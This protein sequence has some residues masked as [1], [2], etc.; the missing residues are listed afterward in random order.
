MMK[1]NL[2]SLYATIVLAM[3]LAAGDATCKQKCQDDFCQ[4]LTTTDG[5]PSVWVEVTPAFGSQSP[6]DHT[7]VKLLKKKGEWES[8]PCFGACNCGRE[9]SDTKSSTLEDNNKIIQYMVN[10]APCKWP[11]EAYLVLG[12][13]HQLANRG[14]FHTGK[15]VK[16]ARMYMWS[17]F[18]Y[19]TYGYNSPHFREYRMSNCQEASSK[20]GT[21]KPGLPP[22]CLPPG[23]EQATP[24]EPD[25]EYQIYMEYFRDLRVTE[26]VQAMSNQRKSYR[27]KILTLHIK[28]QLGDENVRIY[29]P[30]L[31]KE[32]D[33]LVQ[34]K[35]GLDQKLIE[36]LKSM[37]S[38]SLPGN[39]IDEYNNLF[40]ASFTRIRHEM[41][42]NTYEK[43]FSLS[44]YDTHPIDVKMFLP[45]G[46]IVIGP[47]S[48]R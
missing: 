47:S 13:C 46:V 26:S 5:C 11:D 2:Y 42:R 10:S 41:P 18:V 6:A 22:T 12:V 8:F 3:V 24:A 29:L 4:G 45:K 34:N 31:S 39:I 19:Q 36:Y 43:F 23:V 21:W 14:L 28:Q 30:M 32:Q 35:A 9:L 37:M 27:D 1:K 16:N 25:A 17:S 33:V 44:Y 20:I 7:Y 40:N 15:I 38:K 48:S